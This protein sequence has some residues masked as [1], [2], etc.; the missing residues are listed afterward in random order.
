M[1]KK[2][3]SLILAS[4]TLINVGCKKDN[5]VTP[6]D[7][8][9]SGK[10]VFNVGYHNIYAINLNSPDL[11]LTTISSGGEPRVNHDGTTIVYDANSSQGRLDIFT[12]PVMGGASTDLTNNNVPNSDSWPDWSPDGNSIV[13]NRVYYPSY[14]EGLCAMNKD[15]SNLH[16]LTDT[17][18]LAIA[19]M[20]RWSPDGST[21]A[22]LGEVSFNPSTPYSLYTIATDGLHEVLLDQL[23]SDFVDVMPRW[24]PDGQ[25]IA[26]GKATGD[27]Y[28]ISVN[29]GTPEKIILDSGT[30]VSPDGFSWLS[31]DSLICTSMD[32]ADTSYEVYV[33][34]VSHSFADKLFVTGF[35][36]VPTTGVS[37]DKKF[38][39]VFGQRKDDTSLTLYIVQCDGTNLRKV[40][41]T[42]LT[43]SITDNYYSQWIK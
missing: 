6:S 2:F 1:K 34:S 15:G 18:S 8:G 32:F 13:F 39:S 19:V 36:T 12:T 11:A 25:K 29:N 9:L 5:V 28:V 38:I 3:V 24:S 23:G 41:G 42:G 27:L 33:V 14:K 30:S 43:G 26:Y 37:P 10:I 22:F 17:T 16:V 35:K 7:W 20:P 40:K 4:M 31:N 21:I